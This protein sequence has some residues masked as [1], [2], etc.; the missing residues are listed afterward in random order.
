MRIVIDGDPGGGTPGANVDDVLALAYAAASR[1]VEVTAIWTVAGNV[2]SAE[3]WRCTTEMTRLLGWDVPVRR[4]AENPRVRP[5]SGDA[6]SAPPPASP[7]TL[8]SDLAGAEALICLGPATNAARVLAAYPDAV[9]RVWAMAGSWREADTNARLDPAALGVL[10]GHPGLTLVPL[11]LTRQVVLPV[12]SWAQLPPGSIGAALAPWI[13][14]WLA[15]P[16][17]R[18]PP[19]G[20]WV[21]DVVALAGAEPGMLTTREA[22]LDLSPSAT[23]TPGRHQVR[24]ATGANLEILNRLRAAITNRQQ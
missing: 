22:A 20:M 19:Q 16:A 7:D 17:C 18:K 15:H 12:V 9:D 8:A 1:H 3:G 21:H 24:L 5:T 6:R 23:L 14:A 4:G 10:L 13:D 11:T 2:T